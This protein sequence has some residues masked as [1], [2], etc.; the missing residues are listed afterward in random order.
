MKLDLLEKNKISLTPSNKNKNK[1]KKKKTVFTFDNLEDS[2]DL[3]DLKDLNLEQNVDEMDD[4]EVERQLEEEKIL[5][6]ELIMNE[7]LR[8]T[9]LGTDNLIFSYFFTFNF[10]SIRIG[11]LELTL[12]NSDILLVFFWYSSGI[13]LAEQEKERDLQEAELMKKLRT[14]EEEQNASRKRILEI[15]QREEKMKEKELV[16][17]WYTFIYISF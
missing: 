3:K 6:L 17:N 8:L 9:L 11:I 4:E 15:E 7:K 16:R 13:L 5:E 10:F 12:L 1:N 14:V 2:K